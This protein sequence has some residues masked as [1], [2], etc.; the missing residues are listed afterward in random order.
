MATITESW[1]E[2]VTVGLLGTDRRDPPEL[3]PGPLA[4]SVA[5]TLRPTPQGRLLAAVAATVVA[6]RCG[7]RPLPPHPPLM[8]PAA[9]GRRLL[10]VAAVE[11]WRAVVAE[12]PVLEAEWLALATAGPWRPP[13]DLLVAL[14]RRHRRSPVL[15][16]AVL[17]WGGAPAAWLVD[18]VPDLAP[19]D[20]RRPPPPA[21]P[22]TALPVP[23]E[24]EPLLDGNVDQLAAAIDGGLDS[25]DYRWAHRA[26]LLNT[27]ARAGRR[28]LPSLLAALRRGRDAA[29]GA[30]LETTLALREALIELAAVRIAMIAELQ[31]D[32]AEESL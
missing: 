31:Q 17:A 19:L 14:L 30:G 20:A 2:L 21:T 11:R 26:V 6:R 23:A 3:P 29:S 18:Q 24:L 1:D 28:S 10:P 13:P 12:W 4:D 16:G 7:V 8:P 9:D 5:D 27:V 32:P 15:T 25:G 22:A